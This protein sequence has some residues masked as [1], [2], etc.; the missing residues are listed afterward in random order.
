MCLK[1]EKKRLRR[2]AFYIEKLEV[3]PRCLQ[4]EVRPQSAHTEYASAGVLC[5]CRGPMQVQGSAGH[6]PEG[7]HG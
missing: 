6:V 7:Q 3:Y 2:Q 5:K 1:K 4:S